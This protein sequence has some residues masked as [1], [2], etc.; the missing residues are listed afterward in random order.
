MIIPAIMETGHEKI[1]EFIGHA[2]AYIRTQ[3]QLGKLIAV[4]KAGLYFSAAASGLVLFA[5]FFFAAVFA[6]LA[7]AWGIAQWLDSP[8]AGFVA[9][10]ALYLLAGI[11]L[12]L[13]HEQWLRQPL[14]RIFIRNVLKHGTHE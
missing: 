11:V 14:F 3:K 2:E 12:S 13:K 5:L 4:E 9:V 8:Y 6:S 7:L 1:D 10:T